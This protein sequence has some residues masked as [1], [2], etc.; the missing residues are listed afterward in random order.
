MLNG[1]AHPSSGP[2][3]GFK[4]SEEMHDVARRSRGPFREDVAYNVASMVRFG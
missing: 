1:A 2:L 4:M 3:I